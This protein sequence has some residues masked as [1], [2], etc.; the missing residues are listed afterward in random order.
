VENRRLDNGELRSNTSPVRQMLRC[1]LLTRPINI[2]TMSVSC[3][4]EDKII[5]WI[6][7]TAHY[8]QLFL[9]F[10]PQTFQKE[11]LNVMKTQVHRFSSKIFFP[12]HGSEVIPNLITTPH[13]TERLITQKQVRILTKVCQATDTCVFMWHKTKDSSLVG[14]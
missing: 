13:F 11:D 10:L 8:A 12:F 3:S 7:K 9:Y 14:Y 2:F 1:V 4:S 6:Y 5:A